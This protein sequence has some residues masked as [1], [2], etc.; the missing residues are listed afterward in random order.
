M[1]LR[2]LL[3]LT[4]AFPLYFG[5]S[6]GSGEPRVDDL[7][8]R[9]LAEREVSP[10]DPV[11]ADILCQARCMAE[12]HNNSMMATRGCDHMCNYFNRT[13]LTEIC[14]T[15]ACRASCDNLTQGT[16]EGLPMEK[17]LLDDV[18]LADNNLVLRWW[19][20]PCIND[21]HR[22]RHGFVSVVRYSDGLEE[23]SYAIQTVN[24]TL[25][26]DLERVCA[27]FF[28]V[29]FVN[30]FG[31]SPSSEMKTLDPIQV[32][33]GNN[34]TA[35]VDPLTSVQNSLTLKLSWEVVSGWIP[36]INY[37]LDPLSAPQCKVPA[38]DPN[39]EHP[40]HR[41]NIT[42]RQV[43]IMGNELA[44]GNCDVTYEVQGTFGACY[45]IKPVTFKYAFVCDYILRNMAQ[46]CAAPSP[47]MCTVD[48]KTI[49]V[50]DYR[51]NMSAYIQWPPVESLP[52]VYGYIVQW[53]KFVPAD[54]LPNLESGTIQEINIPGVENSYAW[55]TG[56]NETD[57][58]YG[59]KVA[60]NRSGPSTNL[61]M[62]PIKPFEF[63]AV[64]STASGPQSALPLR[65]TQLPKV[66]PI[67]TFLVLVP[68]LLVVAAVV[69]VWTLCVYRRRLMESR[70]S[71]RRL[72]RDEESMHNVYSITPA[73]DSPDT[74]IPDRWEMP[75]ERLE[76]GEVLGK[77]QFGVVM[78]AFIAGKLSTHYTSGSSLF[79][80]SIKR[81]D[82]HVAVK[83]LHGDAEEIQRQEF[84]REMKL[85]KDIG[86]HSNL[87]SLL[88]CCSTDAAPL[89]LIVEHC[90]H[91]DLLR[92][93]RANRG[94]MIRNEKSEK[95]DGTE[96]DSLMPNDLLSFARQIAR[97]MEYL[98]QKGFV[99]RDLAARNVMVAEDKTVKIG[100]FG[101]TRYVYDD[102]IY[103]HRR[104]GKLPI[105]W[106]S[107]EA[108]Y[109][110][111]FTTC[112]DVWSFGVLL[113][114]LVTLG[115]SPYPG[116]HNK[117]I[118]TML[119][120]GDRMQRPENCSEV[121]YAIMIACWHPC[122]EERPTFTHLRNKLEALLEEDTP[123]LDFCQN[124]SHFPFFEISEDLESDEEEDAEGGD[125]VKESETRPDDIPMVS[126]EGSDDDRGM[127]V[128][129]L[130]TEDVFIELE[131]HHP[132]LDVD[133]R[134][135]TRSSWGEVKDSRLELQKRDSGLGSDYQY[136]NRHTNMED[137]PLM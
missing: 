8:D 42:N 20:A 14:T 118:P 56:F 131:C 101:L 80:D 60:V 81:Y 89:C 137:V 78:K 82:V 83:M 49:N 102:N 111:V 88:G 50:T 133:K 99:H 123:Y 54:L 45:D 30:Q 61:N 16:D 115:A 100:D 37:Y 64:E 63:T 23:W 72:R 52:G 6:H 124:Y 121:L 97:G 95:P 106:M 93:L 21:C 11:R 127:L 109:D 68:V 116:I 67:M 119:K 15:A 34:V 85:M 98:S 113:F 66:F 96:S 31:A 57:I 132:M 26:M 36:S 41:Q 48:V 27:K 70:L 25:S 40:V 92:Y 24:Q 12:C 104:G 84:R 5:A 74:P 4:I 79:R 43:T 18:M 120:R 29:V 110:Q 107:V 69:F 53:G 7:T 32:I 105:K 19:P 73:A 129:S 130:S 46:Y 65:S 51:Q 117:D 1:L 28:Q 33:K 39:L 2:G 59:V 91:G 55:L 44:R 135:Q 136:V 112:N 125:R 134:D 87:V 10:Q 128:G 9:P 13:W 108:L 35:R 62:V 47:K 126:I 114:E 75:F 17:P 94:V 122:P 86:R 71:K 38:F 58:T 77:G 90:C 103:V 3:V 22:Q 76:M